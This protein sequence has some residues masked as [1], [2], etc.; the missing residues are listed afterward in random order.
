MVAESSD[1]DECKEFAVKTLRPFW[2]TWQGTGSVE[3]C[4]TPPPHFLNACLYTYTQLAQMLTHAHV[5]KPTALKG[6]LLFQTVK[7]SSDLG[8]TFYLLWVENGS[9]EDM[10]R[11]ISQTCSKSHWCSWPGSSFIIRDMPCVAEQGKIVKWFM[12]KQLFQAAAPVL[13]QR[14]SSA[15]SR[16][17]CDWAQSAQLLVV[18]IA[19]IPTL[20]ALFRSIYFWFKCCEMKVRGRKGVKEY[21][22]S[23]TGGPGLCHRAP[24]APPTESEREE[25][26]ISWHYTGGVKRSRLSAPEIFRFFQ[27]RRFD[28]VAIDKGGE[29]KTE[30]VWGEKTTKTRGRAAHLRANRLTFLERE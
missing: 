18:S 12:Y 13:L 24:G 20:T 28:L 11:A 3:P 27:Q 29:K 8:D 19:F 30:R 23:Q 1:T 22:Y 4:H 14:N 7:A 15:R 25:G 2:E 17:L 5:S 9:P 6:Y 26:P 10:M 16:N 21:S